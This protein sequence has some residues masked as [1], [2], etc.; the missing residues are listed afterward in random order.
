MALMVDI[1]SSVG[2][3][4]RLLA[5][6]VLPGEAGTL[7]LIVEWSHEDPLVAPAVGG[8]LYEGPGRDLLAQVVGDD[9]PLVPGGE[10][11]GEDEDGR[12]EDHEEEHNDHSQ[13]GNWLQVRIIIS[14]SFILVFEFCN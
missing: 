1:N 3:Q 5:G 7:V 6:L 13:N 11:D 2:P 8:V 9:P 12:E 14:W 10:A 4:W